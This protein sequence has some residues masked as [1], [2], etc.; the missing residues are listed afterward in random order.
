MPFL[1]QPMAQRFLLNL[2][3][4]VDAFVLFQLLNLWDQVQV[5]LADGIDVAIHF[6]STWN[7]IFSVLS[8]AYLVSGMWWV[9]KLALRSRS[10]TLRTRE[11]GSAI[12]S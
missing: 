1:S 5:S 3:W 2:L 8:L 11:T 7:L 9:G 6:S 4:A 12:G 10:A